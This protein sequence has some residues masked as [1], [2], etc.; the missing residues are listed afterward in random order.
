MSVALRKL[1]GVDAVKVSLK[2]GMAHIQLKPGNNVSLEQL[3]KAV[4]EQG[5][6]PKDST[7]IVHGNLDETGKQ[8]TFTVSGTNDVYDLESGKTS[9]PSTNIT[10]RAAVT[11]PPD[12]GK[13][14]R[15]QIKEVLKSAK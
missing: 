1:H 4:N 11:L 9:K 3:R 10:I 15:M 14:G 6:T 5:F 12:Q 13:H 2:E 8:T 7:V